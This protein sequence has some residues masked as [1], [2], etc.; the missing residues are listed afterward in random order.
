MTKKIDRNKLYRIITVKMKPT[1]LTITKCNIFTTILLKI[2]AI[3]L[4]IV[5][6]KIMW[7]QVKNK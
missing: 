1:L 7:V 2:L 4:I 5:S 3:T 6:I